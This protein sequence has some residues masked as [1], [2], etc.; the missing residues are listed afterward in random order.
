MKAV[1]LDS[2]TFSAAVSVDCIKRQVHTLIS[3]PITPQHLVVE[4]CLDADII[5]TNK[6]ILNQ[7]LLSK[8]PA[9]KLICVTA[10]GVNNVDVVFAKTL[11]IKVSNVRGYAQ[12]S[13]AQ[14]VFSQLLSYFSQPQHHCNNTVS[15]LWSEGHTF[16]HHGNGSVELAGKTMGIIGY[17][18]LGQAVAKI[19]SAFNM[20][21]LIAE[22]Q[23]ASIIRSGR[24]PLPQVVEQAD[25]LTLHCPETSS[26]QQLINKSVLATMKKSAVLINTARGAIINNKDLYQALKHRDIAWAILDVLDQ[27][28]P[29]KEHLF[30]KQ[31]LDNLQI[32]PHIAWASMEAQQ[33][34]LNLVAK[35]IEVFMQSH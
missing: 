5:I 35:N 1:F 6:V 21:V 23:Q 34:L 30:L 28:P 13:V 29:P 4:R 19:A 31:P 9:L 15:G 2:Q 8:L 17:G 3:H 10:T 7:E 11:G 32:T 25:V 12:N 14:Y 22:R 26:T 16:C 27:E 18:N 33:D 20:K 24:T